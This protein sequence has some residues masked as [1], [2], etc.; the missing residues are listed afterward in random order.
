M[1]RNVFI[2]ALQE[3]QSKV[4]PECLSAFCSINPFENYPLAQ[5]TLDYPFWLKPIKAFSSQLDFKIENKQQFDEA[6]KSIHDHIHHFGGPFNEAL[7]EEGSRLSV[8]VNQNA[9]CYQL[10][11]LFIPAESHEQLHERYMACLDA[12]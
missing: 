3:Q 9:F 10:G 8:L 2:I 11:T 12:L 1:K 4:I 7:D 6:I 5:V